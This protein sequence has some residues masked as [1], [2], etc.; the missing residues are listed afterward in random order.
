MGKVRINGS[1]N[2]NG[3]ILLTVHELKHK[4]SGSMLASKG[5]FKNLLVLL[6]HEEAGFPTTISPIIIILPKTSLP[7]SISGEFSF[8]P[9]IYVVLEK[10]FFIYLSEIPIQGFH[11]IFAV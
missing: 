5:L 3:F 7:T 1:E 10:F 9:S 6:H 2:P 8:L 4:P 11:L